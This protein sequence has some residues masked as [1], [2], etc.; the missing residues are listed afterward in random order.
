MTVAE[1]KKSYPRTVK[2]EDRKVELRKMTAD[3]RDTLLQF[4]RALPEKDLLFLRM[5]ITQP[6]V[7]DDWIE[8]LEAGRRFTILAFDDGEMVGYGSLNRT[9]LSWTRHLGEIRTIVKEGFRSNGLGSLLTREIFAAAQDLGMTKTVVQM[10]RSQH[11]A[12]RMFERLGFQH[13][14][15]LADWVIDRA[16]RTHDLVIMSHDVTSLTT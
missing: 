14:A 5:D 7:I 10:A 16:G 12:Q 4:A 2:L 6:E 13:E 3:D 11:G 8:S 9:L 15:L 1:I